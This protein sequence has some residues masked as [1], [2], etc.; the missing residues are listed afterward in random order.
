MSGRSSARDVA[1]ALSDQC[2]FLDTG[3]LLFHHHGP[4]ALLLGDIQASSASLSRS[5]DQIKSTDLSNRQRYQAARV[6]SPAGSQGSSYSSNPATRRFTP[7]QDSRVTRPGRRRDRSNAA[8][9]YNFTPEETRIYEA[10]ISLLANFEPDDMFDIISDVL[11]DAKTQ[12][13]AQ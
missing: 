1:P 7:I 6:S 8:V 3:T 10:F 12:F 5:R 4:R 11:K 2:V 13:A 9:K